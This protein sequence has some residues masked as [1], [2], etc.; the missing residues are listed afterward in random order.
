MNVADREPLLRAFY[1]AFTGR[2]A[3][4]LEPTDPLYVPILQS[5]PGKDPILDLFRRISWA[6]SESVSLL[7]GFRGNGKS[8][9]L[10]RL[11]KLL[12]EDDCRVILVDLARYTLLTKRIE[13]PDLLLGLMVAVTV[14]IRE[15]AGWDPVAEKLWEPVAHF[16]GSI[17]V[18]GLSFKAEVFGLGVELATRLSRDPTYKELVQK[19]L[20]GHYS[21]IV[22]LTNNYMTGLVEAIRQRSG[23]KDKKVVI[24][25]DSLEQLRGVGDEAEEVQNSVV[26]LFSGQAA[27]LALAQVHMVYTVP[28][29]L[30]ARAPGAARLL[31][32]GTVAVW[33]NIHVRDREGKDD[34]TGMGIMETVVQ[35]RAE[36]WAS[37][38]SS[39][40][41]HELARS[42]GGDLRDYFRLLRECAIALRNSE[43]PTVDAEVLTKVQR[44]LRQ[45]LTQ[46][47]DEDAVWLARVHEKK[48]TALQKNEDLPRLIR[49][50]DSNLIMNYLNGEPWYDLHPLILEDVLATAAERAGAPQEGGSPR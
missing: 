17:Q 13:L 14:E 39:E 41:L 2:R 15:E 19:G 47:A 5:S 37:F 3:E 26:E 8:T 27:N 16:L 33:P 32:G 30:L 12:K 21:S 40:Q 18:E 44:Q 43:K 49:F 50:L 46:L 29:Y 35:K 48:D 11:R 9:E 24:L 31:G 7:T 23:I 34:P 36:N 6:E 38:L 42:T 1:R 22:R 28:P 25:V 10:R 45:E 4:P 20:R